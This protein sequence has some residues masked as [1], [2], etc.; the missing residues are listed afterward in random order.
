MSQALTLASFQSIASSSVPLGCILAYNNTRLSGCKSHAAARVWRRQRRRALG[1]RV[2]VGDGG[3]PRKYA[4]RERPAATAGEYDGGDDD[5][6][7]F[8]RN[9]CAHPVYY[10][11]ASVYSIIGRFHNDSP[12]ADVGTSPIFSTPAPGHREPERDEHAKSGCI[13]ITG[14]GTGT[15]SSGE[16]R[17]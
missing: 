17:W 12:S 2:G 10:H 7:G 14:T 11:S 9:Q 8:Q 3:E 6:D 4:V 16:R 13:T 1:L 5:D 15:A